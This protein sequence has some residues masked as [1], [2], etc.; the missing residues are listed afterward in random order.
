[1]WRPLPSNKEG[2]FRP[3]S[4]KAWQVVCVKLC[5]YTEYILNAHSHCDKR[6][7]LIALIVLE[8]FSVYHP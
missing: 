6:S 5:E 4:H 2:I 8:L 3:L 1:M 7:I